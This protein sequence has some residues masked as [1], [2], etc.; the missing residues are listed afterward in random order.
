MSSEV[1]DAHADIEQLADQ[2]ARERIDRRAAQAHAIRTIKRAEAVERLPCPVD[3]AA[4]QLRRR[5]AP[6]PRRLR[7][8]T[9]AFGFQAM[10]IA[11]RHQEQTI[12]GKADD[13]GFD[14]C[15]V[16]AEHVAAIADRGLTT[17]LRA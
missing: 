16:I 4:E 13:F 11:G 2:L 12:A 8:I 5:L 7:G 17:R 1:I 15:A 10:D 9:R 14:A 3:H 6:S